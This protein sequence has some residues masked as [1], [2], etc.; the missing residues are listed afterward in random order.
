LPDIFFVTG[1]MRMPG[2]VPVSFSRN[3]TVVREAGRL[4]IIN[5]LRLDEQSLR[6]LDALGKVTDVIRIAGFHGMDDPTRKLRK[7]T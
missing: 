1:T 4:V 3:M 5:S 7:R 6:S 2:P